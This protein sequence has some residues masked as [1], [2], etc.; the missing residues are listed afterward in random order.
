[1]ILE[2]AN[3]MYVKENFELTQEFVAAAKETFNSTADKVNFLDPGT[4]KLINTWVEKS[5]HDKI[6]DLIPDGKLVLQL[7]G[8]EKIN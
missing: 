6:K 5:T 4:P 7:F 2:I 8:V 3:K 1:M